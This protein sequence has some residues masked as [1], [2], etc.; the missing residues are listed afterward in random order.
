MTGDDLKEWSGVAGAAAISLIAL[1]GYASKQ[2]RNW[3]SDRKGDQ[4]DK[5]TVDLLGTY[6][7]A[8]ER[9]G[10]ERDRLM[11]ANAKL[12][13]QITVVRAEKIAV[14]KMTGARIIGLEAKVVYLN[15]LVRHLIEHGS[16]HPLP[17]ELIALGLTL[18]QVPADEANGI[19]SS[20][21]AEPDKN[22]QA[23]E[24]G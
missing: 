4:V 10:D 15:E 14:E 16:G 7:V 5:A 19:I 17:P 6:K 20:Y 1:I 11:V 22:D 9:L 2:M 23:E 24:R 13:A 12:E 18:V 8:A 3:T 21:P